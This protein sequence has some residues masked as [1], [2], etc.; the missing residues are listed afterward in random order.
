MNSLFSKIFHPLFVT[1]GIGQIGLIQKHYSRLSSA[2]CINIRITAG[3]RHSRIHQLDE[4]VY[5]F[6]VLLHHAFCFC[7]M[8]RIPLII[9][10][11]LQIPFPL[12]HKGHGTIPFLKYP[13]RLPVRYLPTGCPHCCRNYLRYR[14]IP[15][16]PK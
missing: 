12:L 7:H 16:F 3:K 2:K 13:F 6:D 4:Q 14:K 10:I 11:I 9:H 8:T 1:G 5:K 15:R